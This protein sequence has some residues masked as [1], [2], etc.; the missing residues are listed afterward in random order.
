MD[1][2]MEF[3]RM[4]PMDLIDDQPYNSII[5]NS[6]NSNDSLE[7]S[8]QMT[9]ALQTIAHHYFRQTQF[10]P[11]QYRLLDFQNQFDDGC[12]KLTKLLKTTQILLRFNYCLC[13]TYNTC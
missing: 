10:G 4:D 11:N 7:K 5:F 12:D 9:E 3:I 1:C 6:E 2:W 13:N 8:L